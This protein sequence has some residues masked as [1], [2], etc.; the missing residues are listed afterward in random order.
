MPYNLE[1]NGGELDLMVHAIV[2]AK[3]ELSRK[4]LVMPTQEERELYSRQ[5]GQLNALATTLHGA[6]PIETN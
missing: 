1:L 6:K 2:L 3:E 5:I 4:L